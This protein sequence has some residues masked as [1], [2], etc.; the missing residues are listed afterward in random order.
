MLGFTTITAGIQ[1][2]AAFFGIIN[3]TADAIK[4]RDQEE[5]GRVAQTAQNQDA[6]LA[7][8]RKANDARAQSERRSRADI[9]ADDG[10]RR[11]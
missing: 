6:A 8:V 10:F 7:D 2:I 9:T 3:K 4:A 5:Q 11:D 1:A